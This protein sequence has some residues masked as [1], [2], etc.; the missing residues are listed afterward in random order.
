MALTISPHVST[1]LSH[2][3]RLDVSSIVF[4][5]D[6]N[7]YRSAADALMTDD[8]FFCAQLLSFGRVTANI[9]GAG[10]ID[11]FSDGKMYFGLASDTSLF[12]S[13]ANNLVTGGSFNALGTFRSDALASAIAYAA[14]ATDR[15]PQYSWFVRNDGTMWWGSGALTQD[16]NLYRTAVGTLKTDGKFEIA[17]VGANAFNVSNG[18]AFNI[19]SNNIKVSIGG[20][21]SSGNYTLAILSTNSVPNTNPVGGG[22]LWVESG[23]LKYR[24]SGG[25]VTTIALS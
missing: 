18:N 16:T 4:D 15:T 21:G 24:G 1:S 7:L 13:G 20:Q 10:Q 3:T 6:T 19:D 5:L 9:G 23:A 11:L 14:F 22:V 17:G 8:S 12:R 2:V 25:T